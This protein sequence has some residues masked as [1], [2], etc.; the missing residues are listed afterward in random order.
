MPCDAPSAVSKKTADK[1]TR[2]TMNETDAFFLSL[3]LTC[4]SRAKP[5]RQ[6]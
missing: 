4:I 5:E 6:A 1:R 2:N 3:F